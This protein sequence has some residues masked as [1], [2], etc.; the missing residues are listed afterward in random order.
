MRRGG[1]VLTGGASTRMG[2][3]KA[4]VTVG[5]RPMAQIVADALAAAGCDEVV[6]IGGDAA[7]LGVLSIPVI[8]DREPGS[9]PL[10]GVLA[11]LE[12]FAV[13]GSGDGSDG[14]KPAWVAVAACDLPMLTPTVVT[15]LFDAAGNEPDLDAVVAFSDRLEPAMAVWNTDAGPR[16]RVL[17]DEGER[18]VH[19]ALDRLRVVQVTVDPALLRN[20]NT[21]TDL[22]GY[23]G[24]L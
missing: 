11:A 21:P 2:R 4:L 6:L 20:V 12:W 22:P 1:A 5:G 17:F 9:G 24:D 8:A 14:G 18:A 7:Q 3:D 15:S 13:E 16:L 23:P 19:R 10:G